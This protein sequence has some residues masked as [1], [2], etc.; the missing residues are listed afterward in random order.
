MQL[1]RGRQRGLLGT[2]L[3]TRGCGG[4]LCW[5]IKRRSPGRLEA[6]LDPLDA[7]ITTFS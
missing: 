7:R 4:S 2:L 3:R 5:L 6:P 1:A